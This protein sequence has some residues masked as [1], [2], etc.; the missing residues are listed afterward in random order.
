M[1]KNSQVVKI[2][3]NLKTH[4]IYLN[5][6][7]NNKTMGELTFNLNTQGE[8]HK[9]NGLNLKLNGNISRVELNNYTFD[10]IRIVGDL[11]QEQFTGRISSFDP[12]LRFDFN[13]MV[14]FDT[15][16]SYDFYANVYYA[17]L[18]KLGISKTDTNSNLSVNIKANFQGNSLDN[19]MGNVVISDLFYFTDT[20]YFATDTIKIESDFYSGIK[21]M[22]VTSEFFNGKI[23]G[24]IRA[25]TL[26]SEVKG[27]LNQYLPSV[28]NQKAQQT[29]YN[30][31]NFMLTADYPHPVTE[32]LFPG[33]RISPGTFIQ[34]YFN[35][36]NNMLEFS[37]KSDKINIYNREL[38]D[39]TIRTYTRKG[40]LIFN[41]NS[42]ELKY[43]ESNSLKNFMISSRIYN[44]SIKTNFNWNNWLDINYSGNI[45]SLISFSQK[46]ESNKP[47]VKIN[48]FPSNIILVDT[49]WALPESTVIK[50]S[51]GI[52]FNGLS[53]TSG[54]SRFDLNGKLSRNPN[55]SLKID[56]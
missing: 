27:F 45:N 15:M 24:Q 19:T 23:E 32:L 9:K 33:Y 22:A 56:V 36:T 11:N 18:F 44:D 34:G 26:P 28:F 49:L 46:G 42:D 37:I 50:D 25:L 4:P 7:T 20:T 16:P 41:L 5:R 8:Y 1:E 14:N 3:G 51:S 29:K 13:G 40:N 2:N 10:S 55:D 43:I 30:N 35:A 39:L 48:L 47:T 53:A 21:T 12:N 38:S 31:F 6:V 54:Y 52:C 17:N